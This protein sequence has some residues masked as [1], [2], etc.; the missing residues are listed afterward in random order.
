MGDLFKVMQTWPGRHQA[1]AGTAPTSALDQKLKGSAN[2]GGVPTIVTSFSFPSHLKG[3]RSS[4]QALSS[5]HGGSGSD[6]AQ[7]AI[8][9]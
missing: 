6:G 4:G 1:L 3:H 2:A 9:V 5:A 8:V 7:L